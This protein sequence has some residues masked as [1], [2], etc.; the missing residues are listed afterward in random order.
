M[1]LLDAESR[2]RVRRLV[3]DGTPPSR[4]AA[5]HAARFQQ[6]GATVQCSPDHRRRQP[7]PEH[8]AFRHRACATHC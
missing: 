5:G 1:I 8:G 6:S 4:S 7:A 2:G 3:I